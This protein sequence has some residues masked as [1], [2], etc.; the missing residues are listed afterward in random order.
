MIKPI[1][2]MRN[3]RIKKKS[4]SPKKHTAPGLG[5][6]D[7]PEA[8][9]PQSQLRWLIPGHTCQV[10]CHL[11]LPVSPPFSAKTRSPFLLLW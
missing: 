8:P 5:S 2:Q 11:S 1:L 4:N 10:R 7:P 9:A 3:S 6:V